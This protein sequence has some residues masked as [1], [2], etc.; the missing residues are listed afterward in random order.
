[1]MGRGPGRPHRSVVD[2]RASGIDEAFCRFFGCGSS[3]EHARCLDRTG[4]G[5]VVP[6]VARGGT[7]T[8]G[9]SGLGSATGS[10]VMDG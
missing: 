7:V 8:V 2:T 5:I 6:M 4:T 9:V 1:M 3:A 10:I